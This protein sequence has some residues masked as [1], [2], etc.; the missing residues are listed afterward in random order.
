VIII[1]LPLQCS[2]W[3]LQEPP[4]LLSEEN[5]DAPA[6]PRRP[7]REIERPAPTPTPPPARTA[8]AIDPEPIN[9][10]W[11]NEQRRQQ[12]EYAEEQRRLQE[13][14][15][16][17]LYQQQ[18]QAQQ[19]QREFEEQQRLQLEQQRLAQEQLAREHYQRQTEGRM[20]EL[21]RENLNARAQYE[22]DQL[23]LEQ[24]DRVS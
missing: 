10:F 13:Q 11:K 2:N 17:Q 12:D 15:E 6:L 14:R 9:E 18:L 20:A 24:Y 3:F 4:N 21:E 1:Y 22:Q 23:M 16:A 7:Q 19:A 8:A 5:G